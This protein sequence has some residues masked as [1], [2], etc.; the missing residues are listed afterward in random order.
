MSRDSEKVSNRKTARKASQRCRHLL[1]AYMDGIKRNTNGWDVN[2]RHKAAIRFRVQRHVRCHGTVKRRKIYGRRKEIR[3][4]TRR[5][6]GNLDSVRVQRPA[7]F[8][9]D[10]FR[11]TL[12]HLATDRSKNRPW[13][14]SPSAGKASHQGR[15]H[16]H[17]PHH[18]RRHHHHHHHHL[19]RHHHPHRS[20]D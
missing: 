1:S 16:H 11:W 6:S 9:A 13:W 4:G 19:Q 10:P 3:P 18:H 20:F 5:R 12:R 2:H 8:G 14:P 17:H 15:Y 7:S